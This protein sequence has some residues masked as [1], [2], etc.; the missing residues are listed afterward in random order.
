V[1]L[2]QPYDPVTDGYPVLLW[3]ANIPMQFQKQAK[4]RI[5][6]SSFV[7]LYKQSSCQSGLKFVSAK[8]NTSFNSA[9]S[10][11]K[12]YSTRYSTTIFLAGLT[13]KWVHVGHRKDVNHLEK[14]TSKIVTMHSVEV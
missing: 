14:G 11:Y 5:R 2:I 6:T 9:L 7:I 12:D 13:K 8:T 3:G 10:L 4:I 1:R